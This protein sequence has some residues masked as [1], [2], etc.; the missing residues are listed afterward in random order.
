[1]RTRRLNEFWATLI[2]CITDIFIVHILTSLLEVFFKQSMVNDAGIQE[3]LSRF[4]LS[5]QTHW[6]VWE[7]EEEAMRRRRIN[8][9]YKYIHMY[10]QHWIQ[11]TGP[12]MV[13][14]SIYPCI[15]PTNIF[16]NFVLTGVVQL[17]SVYIALINITFT[18][19]ADA[20]VQSNGQMRDN[21]SALQC[22]RRL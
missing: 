21:I 11:D 20:F 12:R 7:R 22:N 4:G 8:F 15:Y 6:I 3:A 1:M 14:L 2:W 13:E 9:T 10:T 5:L 19:L 16:L 18:N 17:W